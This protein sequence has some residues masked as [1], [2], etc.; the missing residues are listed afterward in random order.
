M[1]G[2]SKETLTVQL[3][4]FLAVLVCTMGSLIFLLLV[5][6]REIRQRAVAFAAHEQAHKELAAAETTP[7][8][9]PTASFPEPETE[10]DPKNSVIVIPPQPERESKP[11]KAPDQTYALALAKRERELGDLKTK[12]KQRTNILAKERQRYE[13]AVA[14][15]KALHDAVIEQANSLKSEVGELEVQLGRLMSDVASIDMEDSSDAERLSIEKQIA[16]MQKRLR[17]AQVAEATAD[18]EKFQ[19]IPFDP[20][21]GTTRRPIFIECTAAGIRFQPEDI[22]ITAADLDGFTHRANPLAA[23]T[24]ALINYWTAW[25]QKQRSPKSEPEPYVLLLVRPDG[26]FAYYVALRMLEP[27]HTAHGYELIDDSTSLQLPE[28]DLAAKAACQ[29]AIDRLMSERENIFR[30]AVNNGVGTSVFGGSARSPGSASGKTNGSQRR[31]VNT[32]LADARRSAGNGFTMSD[33]T[34]D[35]STVGTRSWERVENFEGKPRGRRATGNDSEANENPSGF[36]AGTNSAT[37]GG[38]PTS[39]GPKPLSGSKSGTGGTSDDSGKLPE[40]PRAGSFRNDGTPI[41][42]PFSRPGFGAVDQNDAV[43]EQDGIAADQGDVS[44]IKIGASSK[45][46]GASP[47]PGGMNGS[48]GKRPS[49]TPNAAPSGDLSM[50]G[51]ES[52]PGMPVG[53]RPGKQK[54]QTQ[55]GSSDPSV[56]GG[57]EPLADGEGEGPSESG[58]GSR[59][60]GSGLSDNRSSLLRDPKGS[61]PSSSSKSSQGKSSDEIDKQLEPEMLAGRRWGFSEPG[62]SIGFEREVRVDV[63]PEKLVI[64]EK[65]E[66]PVGDDDSKQETFERFATSLDKYSREWGRPPQGFFWTP[67]LKFVVK[68]EA[69]AHY[70]K[71]NA[72]MTRAGLPTSHEF[73]KSKDT[74]EYG[75]ES[76]PAAKTPPR[77]ASNPR[78]GVNR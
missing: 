51:D 35:D 63:S 19:V 4:P 77:T 20:Q 57:D 36:A 61:R 75:R 49:W 54:G 22:L 29:A 69:N 1:S 3:F 18:N 23:G 34:G 62:A 64:S 55:R 70:E 31:A 8:P 24:G 67:R 46:N 37:K 7:T 33:V 10:P 40:P 2:R 27:I 32:N 6:T 12:W 45:Q 65:Y 74:I 17:A 39:T 78:S 66:V 58:R 25:N 72:M 59:S 16:E 43:T 52:E 44:P 5:T 48:S 73:A 9:A 47:S 76:L 11:I 53:E 42:N 28:P 68:P 41:E 21:T 71:I 60:R 30:A 14:E 26:V 50:G 13:A 15:R 38:T 56:E